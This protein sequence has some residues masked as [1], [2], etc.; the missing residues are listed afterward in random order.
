MAWHK[1]TK[2][3][4]FGTVVLLA[5]AAATLIIVFRHKIADQ[6]TLAGGRRTIASH[7][8]TPVDMTPNY[9]TPADYFDQ[10]TSFPAWSTVPIGFQVF[11]NVPLQIDGMICLWGAGNANKLKIVFPEEILGIAVNQKFETLYVYHGAFFT[12]P[13]RTPVCEVVFRYADGSSVTNQLL[14]GSDILDWNVNSG[15]RHVRPTSPNSRLAWL[16]GTFKPGTK[17]PVCFCLTAIKNPQPALEVASIDLFSCKSQTA[18]C[19][20][21]MTA[22]RSGLMK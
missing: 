4:V 7:Q 2:T 3:I 15:K 12:S 6:L 14:Y 13:N 17:R 19:I 22:G 20:M 1:T 18:A 5:L 16:G 9:T 21:A 10:I 11:D 8:A